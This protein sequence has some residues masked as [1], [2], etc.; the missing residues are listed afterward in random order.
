MPKF[1]KNLASHLVGENLGSEI[2]RA[3]IENLLRRL[4]T[5]EWVD[6]FN[7][8]N[9][10]IGGEL[11]LAIVLSLS[12]GPLRASFSPIAVYPSSISTSA[13]GTLSN[14]IRMLIDLTQKYRREI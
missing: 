11:K 10:E 6:I 8:V 12:R 5:K 3:G 1:I 14:I 2:E 4:T 13:I 7:K 9:G